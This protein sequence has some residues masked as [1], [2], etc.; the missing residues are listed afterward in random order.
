MSPAN[1][2]GGTNAPIDLKM[3]D[4]R[5]G[6]EGARYILGAVRVASVV[7]SIC[8]IKCRC[9]GVYFRSRNATRRTD[10]A[11]ES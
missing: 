8:V 6:V 11:N 2:S 1:A 10:D 3:H 7:R 9:R 4:P 5:G